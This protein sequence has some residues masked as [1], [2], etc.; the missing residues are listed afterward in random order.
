[1]I[2]YSY[3]SKIDKWS[4]ALKMEEKLLER[5]RELISMRTGLCIRSQD[6]EAFRKNILSRTNFLKLS[7]P[8]EYL[9][10][11]SRDT[12]NAGREWKELAILLTTG[13]SY[14]FRDKG[15]FAVIRDWILPELINSRKS[16]RSI[17]IWSAGCSTGEETYS[18]AILMYELLP[19]LK[20]WD[21]LILG[22]DINEESIGK[23]RQGIYSQWSFRM[24]DPDFRRRYFKRRYDAWEL[25]EKIRKMVKFRPGNLLEDRFPDTASDIYDM[26]L[27]L[28]RNVFIYFDS[29]TVAVVLEK[30]TE[31]LNDRGYLMTAHGELYGQSL[32]RLQVK[33]FPESVVYRKTSS[34]QG[35]EGLEIQKTEKR[36]TEV[37]K[38]RVAEIPKLPTPDFQLNNYIK[39]AQRCA[40]SGEYGKAADLCRKALDIDNTA[41]K[42]YFLLAHIAELQGDSGNARDLLKK[43]IYLDPAFVAAYLEIG[44]LYERGHDSERAKKMRITAIELLRVLPPDTVIEPYKGITA[45]ELLEYVKKAIDNP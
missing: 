18:L 29:A 33:M 35:V 45:G 40:D 11:L 27:V 26:D 28:C 38:L 5:F 10:L 24:T 34:E 4:G 23:A 16:K 20:S 12:A 17:R 25:D 39:T 13:E 6:S 42:P 2:L 37:E 21:I 15:Q 32:G 41:V 9:R 43:A 22:T 36:R 44:A 1:M 14:F 8:E 3:H 31:T 30:F 7:G 19:Q